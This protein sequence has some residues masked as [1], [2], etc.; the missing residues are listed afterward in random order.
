MTLISL[1]RT[2]RRTV[3]P[4]Y[5]YLSTSATGS[6]YVSQSS[7]PYFNLSFEDWQVALFRHKETDSP[8]LFLYRDQPCV[9]IGRNQNPWKEVNLPS[10]H[11]RG[12]PFI[13]RRSGGGTV[14]HDLGNT[15]FSIHLARTAFDRGST[16]Q[17]VLSAV[18]ALGIDAALNDRND[19]TVHGDKVS[20]SAYK[21]VNKR[22]Y[23]HGT[24][25]IST[26]LNTL[27]DLLRTN[28]PTMKTRGV[29]SVRSPVCNL[30]RHNI[31][32]THDAFCDSMIAVFRDEYSDASPVRYVSEKDDNEDIRK[33]MNEMKSWNWAYGQTPEF[34]YTIQQEFP[35]GVVDAEI[36]A[37]Y[38]VILSCNIKGFEDLGKSFE[39]VRYG[40]AEN[41]T[42]NSTLQDDAQEVRKW[43]IDEMRH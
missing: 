22:A 11:R 8:L 37:K 4:T 32:T 20:G 19:V 40:D 25:L 28:K 12:I 5:R 39:G 30:Q 35:W 15:N 6:I 9:V 26:D 43:I 18:R 14:Y 13:R 10:L 17:S 2:A 23:H 41:K 1:L 27:G 38:G 24:M 7:N 34:T 21:I 29:A 31:A 42:F 36:H 3:S 33:G 16:G